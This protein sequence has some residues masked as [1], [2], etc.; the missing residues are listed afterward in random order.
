MTLSEVIAKVTDLRPSEYDHD[1]LT[2]WLNE[3]EF[4]AID[5]VFSRAVQVK[6]PPDHMEPVTVL[7]GVDYSDIPEPEED[8]E[9]WKPYNYAEDGEKELLIPQQFTSCYLDYLFAKIDFHNGEIARYNVDAQQF[10]ADWQA[11]ASWY[12]RTHKPRRIHT[13][14]TTVNQYRAINPW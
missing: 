13:H 2:H 3:V 5:Q 11:F 10:E 4:M 12:R 9:P 14:E 1:D 7:P 6:K 8:P